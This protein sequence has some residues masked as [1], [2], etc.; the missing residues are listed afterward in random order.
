[1]KEIEWETWFYKPGRSRAAPN[2]PPAAPCQRGSLLRGGARR[3]RT[4][5]HLHQRAR[6]WRRWEAVGVDQSCCDPTA[7]CAGGEE[8]STGAFG[9]TN[10]AHFAWEACCFHAFALPPCMLPQH[11]S[12]LCSPSRHGLPGS[13]PRPPSLLPGMPPV[14]NK[15]DESLGQ[16]AY[17][18]AKK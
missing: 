16:Q 10:Q 8:G 12:P 4:H 13:C 18:L 2:P 9:T 5:M 11:A 1:M 3:P 15:Y 6:R 14:T 17:E 7:V